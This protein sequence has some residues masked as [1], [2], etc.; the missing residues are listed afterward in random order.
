MIFI[1]G[2]EKLRSL[3]IK[4]WKLYLDDER[5]PSTEDEWYVARNTKEAINLYLQ[6]GPADFISFDHDLGGDDNAMVFLK[7]LTAN[8]YG[9]P[10]D[11][12]VHSANPIGRDNIISFIESWKK[13]MECEDENVPEEKLSNLFHQ[14]QKEVEAKWANEE[15]WNYVKKPIPND[16]YVAYMCSLFH[17]YCQEKKI[18]C[19]EY[20]HLMDDVFFGIQSGEDNGP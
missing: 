7:W 8:S 12:Q 2:A 4:S 13:I 6:L 18:T 14:A 10:K 15:N 19:E 3:F 17:T 11:Y 9:P 5:N 20:F 16:F 1:Y